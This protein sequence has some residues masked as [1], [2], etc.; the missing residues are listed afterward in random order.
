MVPEATRPCGPRPHRSPRK[1]GL[2]SGGPKSG[3]FAASAIKLNKAPNARPKRSRI[4]GRASRW[5]RPSRRKRDTRSSGAQAELF[6][7]SE[8]LTG[9]GHSSS[10]RLNIPTGQ[11]SG[12]EGGEGVRLKVRPNGSQQS[13]REPVGRRAHKC[14]RR[15]RRA[16]KSPWGDDKLKR[17]CAR[18]F[19]LPSHASPQG[20]PFGAAVLLLR[21]AI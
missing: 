20:I 17:A 12:P 11:L 10:Q 16:R 7:I 9:I 14:A 3:G 19:N 13:P 4:R 1:L 21:S 15:P 18:F 5:C 6:A 8:R 2:G